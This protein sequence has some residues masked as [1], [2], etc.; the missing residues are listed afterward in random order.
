M[1]NQNIHDES[2]VPALKNNKIIKLCEKISPAVN[3]RA[4]I[5]YNMKEF[6]HSLSTLQSIGSSH[7]QGKSLNQRYLMKFLQVQNQMDW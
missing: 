5:R 1:S 2:A 7:L 4:K 6:D 3:L